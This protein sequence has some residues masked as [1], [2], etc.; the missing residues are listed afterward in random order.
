[1]RPAEIALKTHPNRIIKC[2]VDSIIW[3][4]GTGQLPISGVIPQQLT[5]P[6]PPGYFAVRLLPDAKDKDL[7]LAA[8]AAGIG[9]VYTEHGVMVHIIRKVFLRVS[10]KLD[11]LVLKLH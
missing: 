5:Q 7:F 2:K 8:G 6:M 4:S 10:T 9:A 1:M 3:A 11:W